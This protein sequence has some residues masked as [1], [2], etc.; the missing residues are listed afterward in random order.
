MS[1]VF[2]IVVDG[3]VVSIGP[4]QL[5]DDTGGCF[6]QVRCLQ[7]LQCYILDDVPL[8]WSGLRLETRTC[9]FLLYDRLESSNQFKQLLHHCVDP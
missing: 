5:R 7:R 8:S 4:C 1:R 9:A 6:G 2:P 3:R